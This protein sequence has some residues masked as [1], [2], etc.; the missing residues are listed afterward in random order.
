VSNRFAKGVIVNPEGPNKQQKH[1]RKIN[2][3]VRCPE[4]QNT[5][6]EKEDWLEKGG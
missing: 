5:E 3:I 6:S 4:F 1:K 2:G